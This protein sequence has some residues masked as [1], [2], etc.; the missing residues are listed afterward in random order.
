MRVFA[1]FNQK[2]GCGKTTTSVNLASSFAEFGKKVLLVDIDPQC[3][4]S[5]WLN[6]TNHSVQEKVVRVYQRNESIHNIIHN[7][8]FNNLSIIP[9]SIHI[10]TV[11]K[12]PL[13]EPKNIK[14]TF[15]KNQLAK[16]KQGEY[17]IVV[18]DC[19]PDLGKLTLSALLAANELIVPV[20]TNYMGISVLAE[21]FKVFKAVH[22]HYNPNLLLTGI[23]CSQHNTKKKHSIEVLNAIQRKFKTR[24]LQ[25]IINEDDKLAE[26]PSFFQ[27]IN[28]Y[29]PLSQG[30]KDFKNLVWELLNISS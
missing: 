3:S 13:D 30:A 23:L 22:I 18:I 25:T 29:A 5:K 8:N 6:L 27:P 2:G 20:P 11:T 21:V 19:P 9:S 28:Y 7:T 4:T 1:I 24:V 26:C 12:Y 10:K 17:D 16:L 15:L 14:S